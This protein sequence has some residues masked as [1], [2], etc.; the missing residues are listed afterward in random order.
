M[1][2]S[3]TPWVLIV[4]VLFSGDASRAST[5][6][7]SATSGL[8]IDEGTQSKHHRPRLHE[9]R[10]L[11]RAVVQ[12]HLSSALKV[13]MFSPSARQISGLGLV[14]LQAKAVR[15]NEVL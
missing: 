8:C 12:E 15:S 7:Q 1:F 10:D 2:A 9:S 3:L 4:T 14:P 11:V 13:Q 5:E 6:A